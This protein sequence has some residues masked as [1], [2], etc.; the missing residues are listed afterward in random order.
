[1][2]NDQSTDDLSDADI[3]IAKSLD[4][5]SE[6]QLG[7]EQ[8]KT[9]GQVHILR[10]E[11]EYLGP[12]P[13]PEHWAKYEEVLPG[14]ADR[15]LTEVEKEAEHRRQETKHRRRIEEHFAH[16]NTKLAERGQLISL[17]IAILTLVGG[18]LL[19]YFDRPWGVT[20]ILVSATGLVS[21]FLRV[22]SEKRREQEDASKDIIPAPPPSRRKRI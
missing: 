10:A 7:Q 19:I 12:L 21:A 5:G 13:H 22:V 3:D 9:P 18:G 1:M 16:S 8:V 2:G 15:I 20:L 14:A 17:G 4:E 11:S 6:S